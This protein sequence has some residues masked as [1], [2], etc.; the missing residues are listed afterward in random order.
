MNFRKIKKQVFEKFQFLQS[1]LFLKNGRKFWNFFF[2]QPFVYGQ[3]CFVPKNHDNWPYRFGDI[4]TIPSKTWF[5]TNFTFLA[6]LTHPNDQKMFRRARSQF[7][8]VLK[9]QKKFRQNWGTLGP[10]VYGP[11]WIQSAVLHRVTMK[12]TTISI[13]SVIS[14]VRINTFM[15]FKLVSKNNELFHL[16]YYLDGILYYCRMM[17]IMIC[18][19]YDSYQHCLENIVCCHFMFDAEEVI[20]KTK[21]LTWSII[22]IN[23]WEDVRILI[24]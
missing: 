10:K 7:F 11:A 6:F 17:I 21:N 3:R 20:F 24:S 23:L 14:F 19:S 13:T 12:E 5:F 15:C 1:W 22:F 16:F 9:H 4:A 8:H 18:D 2:C